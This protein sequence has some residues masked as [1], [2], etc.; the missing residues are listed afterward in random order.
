MSGPISETLIN[1]TVKE[2][3]P[4]N[5][6]EACY[7]AVLKLQN[8]ENLRHSGVLMTMQIPSNIL[9]LYYILIASYTML[10]HM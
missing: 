4:I 10:L 7:T 5:K 8:V 6:V 9:W 1:A 3:G 2:S